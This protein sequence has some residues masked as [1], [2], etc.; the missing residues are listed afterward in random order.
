[1]LSYNI[2][3]LKK[4]TKYLLDSQEFDDFKLVEASI[5]TFNLFK[6]NGKN[7]KDYYAE[8][9]RESLDEFSAW[10]RVKPFCY[11]IIKGKKLPVSFKIVFKLDKNSNICSNEELQNS[12]ADFYLNIKYEDKKVLIVSGCSYPEF[13]LDK[14][15]EKVWDFEVKEILKKLEIEYSLEE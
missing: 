5:V 12:K 10:S 8:S 4:F 3:N 13:T 9:E 6:I 7:I 14:S 15:I 11:Q 1:M 2:V